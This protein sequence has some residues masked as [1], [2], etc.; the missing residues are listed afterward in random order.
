MSELSEG[1]AML[2]DGPAALVAGRL[3]S[4]QFRVEDR[5]GKPATDVELYMGT[6]GHAAFIK[7]DGSVFAHIHPSG[8]VP[9]PPL[10]LTLSN[11]PP[12][13]TP[14]PPLLPPDTAL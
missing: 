1:P 5:E 13:P 11:P 2:G 6:Q 7:T 14:D 9:L 8:T 12:R 10:P 4:F 3:T